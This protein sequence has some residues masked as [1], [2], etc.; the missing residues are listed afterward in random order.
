MKTKVFLFFTL[1]YFN[2]FCQDS[3]V[4]NYYNEITS[5]SEYG[6]S[7]NKMKFKKD[8]YVYIQ[9]DCNQELKEEVKNVVSEL[10]ELI[11]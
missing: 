3:T 10:N 8:I 1:F 4:I 5:G 6:F 7:N 9:G 11:N 2:L